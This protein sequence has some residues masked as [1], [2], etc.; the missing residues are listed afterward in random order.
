MLPEC[1]T[2][3]NTPFQD[4][5]SHKLPDLYK[6]EILPAP[7]VSPRSLTPPP[8]RDVP[9]PPTTQ[10]GNP[11]DKAQSQLSLGPSKSSEDFL[12]DARKFL[13]KFSKFDSSKYHAAK[14][15]L[16]KVGESHFASI[17]MNSFRRDLLPIPGGA[18]IDLKTGA[19]VER[20]REHYFSLTSG[21]SVFL[22]TG[23]GKGQPNGVGS[24]SRTSNDPSGSCSDGERASLPP[25]LPLTDPCP[26]VD[27][28]MHRLFGG[29]RD[30]IDWVQR[31]FGLYL[32]GEKYSK[33]VCL[34]GGGGN[35]K[36]VLSRWLGKVLGGLSHLDCPKALLFDV[37][38]KGGGSGDFSRRQDMLVRA[39][40]DLESK[41]LLVCDEVGKGLCL[42][43]EK[44]KQIT[45]GGDTMSARRLY[46]ESRTID[47][48]SAKI[49]T[50][51]NPPFFEVSASS[52]SFKRRLMVVEVKARFNHN[53]SEVD[54]ETVFPALE[55][56]VL[57]ELLNRHVLE[58]LVW[59][60][61]GSRRFYEVGLDDEPDAVVEGTNNFFSE[62]DPVVKFF[63]QAPLKY[64]GSPSDGISLKELSSMWFHEGFG[65][66]TTRT[67]GKLLRSRTDKYKYG[68]EYIPSSS[69]GKAGGI[70]GWRRI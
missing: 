62:Q 68:G 52:F 53:A 63:E 18:C 3:G 5:V 19:I 54:H 28:M 70:R 36:S 39:T 30:V 12:S 4:L 1:Q 61:K 24:P 29:D 69:E 51:A 58:F 14:Y 42:N 50:L 41:R 49:I 26:F 38:E 66:I 8:S 55:P 57:D 9:A 48:S 15:I 7:E 44:F 31:V 33:M 6:P 60:V 67:L 46:Q 21:L 56:R 43:E 64:T 27:L 17:S 34:Y 11:L 65:S 45:G 32:S 59:C 13:T 2:C 16:S 20:L 37:A 10:R 25:P 35:G 47:K 22:G 40:N 23:Q